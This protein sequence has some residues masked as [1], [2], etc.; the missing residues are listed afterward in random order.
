MH[1]CL[2]IPEILAHIFSDIHH[3]YGTDYQLDRTS[4]H[5][6]QA[7]QRSLAALSRVCHSFKDIALDVLWT[8]LDNLEPLFTCLPHDLWIRTP[9]RKLVRFALRANCCFHHIISMSDHSKTCNQC[10]LGHLRA[11]CVPGARS[12]K[13]AV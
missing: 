2:L 1:A 6:R 9:E 3:P 11:I 4:Q 5:R 7:S 8:E 12:G 10:R 13:Q